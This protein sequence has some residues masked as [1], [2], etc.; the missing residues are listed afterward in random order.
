MLYLVS[1]LGVQGEAELDAQWPDRREPA[2][3]T[4]DRE[5]HLVPRDTLRDRKGVTSIEE[6]DALEPQ[7]L[8]DREDDLVVEDELLAAADRVGGDLH[9]LVGDDVGIRS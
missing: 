7:R 3:A 6:D 8:D 1:Y 9:P 4:A 5:A 2:D